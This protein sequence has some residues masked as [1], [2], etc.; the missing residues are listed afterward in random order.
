MKIIVT[1]A[2]GFIGF[3]TIKKLIN[4][5]TFEILG[6]DII[7]DY[8]DKKL[9]YDRLYELGIFGKIYENKPYKKDNLTF[10]QVDI[11]DRVSI[12][13]VFKNFKPDI[14][15]HL[16]AQ[17]G[18]RYS[19]ENPKTYIDTNI[20]GFNNIIECSN[21]N[22][23]SHFIYASSSSVYGANKKIP[24]S[25]EDSTDNPISL[26]ASSKK[27]N[28]L[29]AYSFSE[30]FGMNTTG[31]RFFTVYGSWGRPDMAYYIFA[32]AMRKNTSIN[33]FNSGKM[34]RDFTHIFDIVDCIEKIIKTTPK[35]KYN[36]YNIGNN[37]PTTLS[38]FISIIEDKFNKPLNKIYLEK[39]KG[40]VLNTYADISHTYND[41]KYSPNISIE[42]GLEE[43]ALWYKRYYNLKI[44]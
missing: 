37:K 21:I 31:L 10:I 40:D 9:K 38:K 35:T 27:M 2:C 32:D 19:F 43:F 26:Y 5:T 14:V 15:L 44:N 30:N 12:Q 3:H 6:I 7:N 29:M 4:S 25:I 22:K 18:V 17:A 11:C 41:F 36:I 42:E 1:G 39:P 8:Y 24:F 34:S 28:E 23:V 33:V 16:A 20:L 13:N